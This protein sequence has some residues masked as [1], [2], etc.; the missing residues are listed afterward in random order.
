M[1]LNPFA[2]CSL[3][4]T[5]LFQHFQVLDRF[6]GS[7]TILPVIRA[8]IVLWGILDTDVRTTVHFPLPNSLFY[9]A[10]IDHGLINAVHHFFDPIRREIALR[11]AWISE[12]HTERAF[13]I[14]IQWNR[15]YVFR[16][17]RDVLR[18]IIRRSV[19]F[20]GINTENAEVT[21]MA[22]PHPVVRVPPELADWRRRSKN[23]PDIIKITVDRKPELVSGVIRIDNSRQRRVL[24][25]YLHADY[26]HD[27][28]DNYATF[29]FRMSMFGSR[30]HT[31]GHILR[32][33]KETDI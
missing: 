28:V 32:T 27:R 3:G 10:H 8:F 11:T 6:I 21:C 29:T 24:L 22:R 20:V 5:F 25:W 18:W 23:Q 19:L 7:D 31:L 26:I 4:S 2:Q 15:S 9:P 33:K 12:S 1:R 16:M 30:E 14:S 13:F 17:I